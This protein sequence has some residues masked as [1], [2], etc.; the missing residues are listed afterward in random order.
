MPGYRNCVRSAVGFLPQTRERCI[1]LSFD[2]FRHSF[3][4]RWQKWRVASRSKC[5]IETAA[6]CGERALDFACGRC[7]ACLKRLR[8]VRILLVG[9]RHHRGW[10]RRGSAHR[11]TRKA[12]SRG[13]IS[14]DSDGS[15]D[16]FHATSECLRSIYR[17]VS[18]AACSSW[19]ARE[20]SPPTWRATCSRHFVDE[21]G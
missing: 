8:P 2:H 10:Q 13:G 17:S 14:S 15:E 19:R 3:G 5:P 11:G 6:G 16:G 12:A 1:G 4:G 20:R 9:L 21:L 18:H 7:F